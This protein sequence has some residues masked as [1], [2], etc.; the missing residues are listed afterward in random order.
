[1]ARLGGAKP[2]AKPQAEAKAFAGY[3][4]VVPGRKRGG[5]VKTLVIVVVCLVL[6][7]G[8]LF[9]IPAPESLQ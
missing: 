5:W 2:A 8:L 3:D 6:L 1:M 4:T 7:I 9:L